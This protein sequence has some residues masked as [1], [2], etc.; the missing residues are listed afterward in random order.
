VA[1]VRTTRSLPERQVFRKVELRFLTE[2][3]KREQYRVRGEM[4][5]LIATDDDSVKNTR[6]GRFCFKLLPCCSFCD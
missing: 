1:S 6:K 4:E 3:E 2:E 5:S